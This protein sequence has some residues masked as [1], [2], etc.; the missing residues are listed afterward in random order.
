MNDPPVLRPIVAKVAALIDE[1]T[2]HDELDSTWAVLLRLWT[3]VDR[4]T[5]NPAP[6]GGSGAP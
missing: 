5:P 2:P 6:A 1:R 4:S 3:A